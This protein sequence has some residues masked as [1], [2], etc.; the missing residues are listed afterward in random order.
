M[1]PTKN[2]VYAHTAGD[3]IISYFLSYSTGECREIPWGKTV[4]P[5]RVFP[6]TSVFYVNELFGIKDING[7]T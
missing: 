7:E 5:A 3:P 6:K 1:L 4:F 2:K